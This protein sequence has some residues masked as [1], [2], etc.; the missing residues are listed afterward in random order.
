VG[1]YSDIPKAFLTK[2]IATP[3]PLET[4]IEAPSESKSQ[5]ISGKLSNKQKRELDSLP[6]KIAELEALQQH[7]QQDIADPEFYNSDKD[8]IKETLVKLDDVD[9]SIQELYERWEELLKL[10]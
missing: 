7:L 9:K 3:K 10:E 6:G 5:I 2:K 1:G 8:I 4:P